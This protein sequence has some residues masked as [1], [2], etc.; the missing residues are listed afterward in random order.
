MQANSII[1]RILVNPSIPTSNGMRIMHGYSNGR[2]GTV[3][4]ILSITAGAG[5][6]IKY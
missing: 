3:E 4:Y 5:G 1:V 6:G 2:C